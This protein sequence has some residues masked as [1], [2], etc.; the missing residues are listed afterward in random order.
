MLT[1]NALMAHAIPL[2]PRVLVQ[3]A[4]RRYIA[5]STVDEAVARIRTLNALGCAA[6]VDV[7][8]EVVADLRQAERTADEYIEVLDAVH[9]HDLSANVSVKP[10]ALGLL[11]DEAQCEQNILRIVRAAA[12]HGNFVRVDMEDASCTQREIDLLGRLRPRHSNVGLVLQAYL[13]RTYRDIELLLSPEQNL[14]ICKGIYVEDSQHLVDG[15]WQDRRTINAHFLHHV[16]RCFDTGTFVGVATHD[17][18]LVAS[19]IALARSRN[20]D[21]SRFEFQMLL[22]VCEPLRDQLLQA[23]YAVRIYVPYGKDWYGYSTRRIKEN[24]QIAG[25]L[26]RALLNR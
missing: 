12:R 14:R 9:A 8:G 13:K 23:G 7:L 5:G 26:V 2:V 1:F 21:R 20:V 24:P 17:A 10:S 15:A 3:K 6:T 18:A 22:G 16:D 19:V 4:S 25:H 11:L